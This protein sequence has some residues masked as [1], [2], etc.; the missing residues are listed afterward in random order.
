MGEATCPSG[1]TMGRKV[2]TLALGSGREMSPSFELSF[3]TLSGGSG[4][5]PSS[6]S[7]HQNICNPL[8][9]VLP[10]PPTSMLRGPQLAEENT[11]PGESV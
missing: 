7:D 4:A 3:M 9:P 2:E 11:I 5:C 8:S 10:P 1:A 6:E